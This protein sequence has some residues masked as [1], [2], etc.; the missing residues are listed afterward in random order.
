MKIRTINLLAFFFLLINITNGQGLKNY[1]FEKKHYVGTQAFMILTPILD[2]SPKY[3]QL[4]YGFRF[5][6]KDELSIEAITWAYQ[7]PL[8]I[9]YGKS[10]Q[11]ANEKFPGEV[12]AFGI[13]LAYKRLLWKGIYAQIHSTALHQN[14]NDVDGNTIQS[15]FQLF[16]VIRTGYHFKLFKDRLFIAPSIAVTSW[17]INTNL[18]ESFQQQEDKWANFFLFEPGLHIGLNF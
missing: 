15:G 4:N 5:T 14:Y 7:A 6:K 8:G 18:P 2:P 11:D 16:N 9:P 17:P 1:D 3:Y 10:Q 12:R 13:G